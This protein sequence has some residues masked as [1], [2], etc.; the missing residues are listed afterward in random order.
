MERSVEITTL[1]F[2]CSGVSRE[3]PILKIRLPLPQIKINDPRTKPQQGTQHEF[4]EKPISTM[5]GT[6]KSGEKSL[7]KKGRNINFPQKDQWCI[8]QGPPEESK[9]NSLKNKAS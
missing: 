9:K 6:P 3:E 5:F 2:F 4:G 8:S 1:T 7:T